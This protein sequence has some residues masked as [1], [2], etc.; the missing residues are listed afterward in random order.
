MPSHVN[1]EALGYT[2]D[3]LRILARDNLSKAY[4]MAKQ[5]GFKG[6]DIQE[7]DL[8]LKAADTLSVQVF[9]DLERISARLWHQ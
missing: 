7:L 5:A 9:E 4:T 8:A 6:D 1:A 2:I 3:Q